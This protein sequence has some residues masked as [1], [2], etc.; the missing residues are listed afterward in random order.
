L[1]WIC[2]EEYSSANR[3]SA[4]EELMK[5]YTEP[6]INFNYSDVV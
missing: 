5:A 3:F 2:S 6:L 1:C 4:E